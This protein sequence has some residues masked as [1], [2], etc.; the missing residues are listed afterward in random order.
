MTDTPDDGQYSAIT[1]GTWPPL[2][3]PANRQHHHMLGH[4]RLGHQGLRA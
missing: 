3:R 2:M 4:Q 1:A